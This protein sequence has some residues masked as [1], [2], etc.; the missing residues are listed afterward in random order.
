MLQSD[1]GTA[2]NDGVA[3]SPLLAT[4]CFGLLASGMV[5]IFALLLGTLVRQIRTLAGG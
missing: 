5:A 2:G 4:V 1:D 3:V